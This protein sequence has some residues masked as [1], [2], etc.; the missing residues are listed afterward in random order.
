[1]YKRD[2]RAGPEYRVLIFPFIACSVWNDLIAV[3]HVSV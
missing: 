3:E 2:Y 1:M